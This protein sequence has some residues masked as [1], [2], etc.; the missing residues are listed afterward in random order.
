MPFIRR[1]QSLSRSSLITVLTVLFVFGTS[2]LAE[3]G[4][5]SGRV[6]TAS[7]EPS[8]GAEVE[9]P[10]LHKRTRTDDDGNYFFQGIPEGSWVVRATSA[11]HGTA[12]ARAEVTGAA[13]TDLDLELE[14]LSHHEDVVVTTGGDVRT[15]SDSYQA[16]D[17]LDGAELD[18]KLQPTLGETLASE[19]GISSTQFGPGASRPIIRGLGGDRIRILENGI[20]TG[21]ASNTSPDH[22]VSVEVGNAESV[23]VI[24]GP[25]SL[26]YGSNAI[27]G[28]INVVDERVPTY[29]PDQPVTGS[30]SLL[31]GSAADERKGS[32][33]L[34][35]GIGQLA[36]NLSYTARDTDDVDIPGFAESQR[37]RAEEEEEHHEE[38]EHEEEEGEEHEEEEHHEE[39]HA[40]GVLPN[41]ALES[42]S[43]SLGLSYVG[44]WG[45]VGVSVSGFDSLYGVPA[46][47]A[48]GH[49]EEEHH[50]EEEHEEE[51]GEEH[52]EEGHHEEEEEVPVRIDMEQRR[53]DLRAEIVQPMGIFRSLKF[54]AGTTDYEH[55]ELEGVEVGTVFDNQEWEARME[56]A[57]QPLGSL[58]GSFGIQARNRDFQAVGEEAF[59]PPTET[60]SLA[61][62]LVEEV[63]VGDVAF[64][65]G[66]RVD[67]TELSAKGALAHE[68]GHHEEEEE[69]EEHEEEEEHHEEEGEPLPDRSFTDVSVS[70][71]M[72]WSLGDD[73]SIAAS[74]GRFVKHP[75]AE[76]L[77]SNGPH[78]ATRAFE[79]GDPN[80]SEETAL[81][82]DVAFRKRHGRLSGEVA[83]FYTQYDDYIYEAFTG[84]EEDGLEEVQYSQADAEFIGGEL[85]ADL[86]LFHSEAHHLLLEGLF[87]F[88]RA[89]LSN[90]EPLPRIPPTRYGLALV[91]QGERFWGRLDGRRHQKQNRVS[92]FED[93]TDAYTLVGATVGY[94]FFVG[95]TVHA[96]TLRGTNL[97]DEEARNHT[98]F[99]KEDVPLPGRDIS[100]SYRFTF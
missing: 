20:G 16:V 25:A 66:A 79:V 93:P 40:F 2:A 51:E 4:G 45:F 95:P 80:L 75:T 34:H 50:E 100:L 28:V 57:H 68:H 54:R 63:E 76:E 29:V 97:T 9:L 26:L 23:E 22:A 52:E 77:Y 99:L 41:S 70:A 58:S 11:R 67:R 91:Y 18:A 8:A 89:E 37:R 86:E 94:R 31:G 6:L 71:G 65:F 30:L 48:H 49:G 53:F 62:F 14:L 3:Q 24:R 39:E 43:G 92:A 32:A 73:Y 44:D 82:F 74:L 19:P 55:T 12:V 60:D 38:E 13:S 56:A 81:G 21:D 17:V 1:S 5:L 84:E 47:H 27:G 98:S 78:L 36:W 35:G 7:G 85:H 88:V 87:D 46:G 33:S 69:G 15:A 61:L 72:V 59:V 64:Q 96:I 83:F 90:G 42:D 10:A